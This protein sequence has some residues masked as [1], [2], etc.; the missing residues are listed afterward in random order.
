MYLLYFIWWL[1][2]TW[3]KREKPRFNFWKLWFK[4]P[5]PFGPL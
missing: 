4:K 2:R 1:F 3:E 5:F